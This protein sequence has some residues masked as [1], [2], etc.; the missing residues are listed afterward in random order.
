MQDDICHLQITYIEHTVILNCH[1]SVLLLEV[2]GDFPGKLELIYK[3]SMF[4]KCQFEGSI[5]KNKG[6]KT[7]D[8]N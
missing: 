5:L 7:N 3:L 6:V 8:C 1:N 4:Y 2:L